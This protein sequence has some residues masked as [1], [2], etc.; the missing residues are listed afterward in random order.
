MRI[1]KFLILTCALVAVTLNNVHAVDADELDENTYIEASEKSVSQY[2]NMYLAV[3]T[4]R[5]TDLWAILGLK[6]P[7]NE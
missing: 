2:L 4:P 3:L 7:S 6:K 5:V 1:V